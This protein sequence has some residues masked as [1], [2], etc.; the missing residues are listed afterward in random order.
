MFQDAYICCSHAIL[1]TH[2][3]I[4]CAAHVQS[5]CGCLHQC[6]GAQI[7]HH[8]MPPACVNLSNLSRYHLPVALRPGNLIC[9]SCN[10]ATPLHAHTDFRDMQTP[11]S[12][13]LMEA[14]I[15]ISIRPASDSLMGEWLLKPR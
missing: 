10:A 7:Y 15:S 2:K 11:S 1:K 12:L 3:A 13:V 14:L 8:A 9:C 6:S 5:C 4:V